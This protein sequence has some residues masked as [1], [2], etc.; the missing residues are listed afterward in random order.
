MKSTG[1]GGQRKPPIYDIAL[2]IT[3]PLELERPPAEVRQKALG[4]TVPSRFIKVKSRRLEV[5]V[6][7]GPR[8]DHVLITSTPHRSGRKALEEPVYC[9]CESF[10][11]RFLSEEMSLGCKHIEGLKL[12]LKGEAPYIKVNVKDP[13]ELFTIITE[14]LEQGRSK[15]LRRFLARPSVQGP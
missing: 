10:Q 9:S 3:S 7:I 15:T 2:A 4:L 11:I 8:E 5:W 13:S 1:S 6:Y 14:V 12:V